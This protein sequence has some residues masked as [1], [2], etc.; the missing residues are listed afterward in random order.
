VAAGLDGFGLGQ[1]LLFGYALHVVNLAGVLLHALHE[2]L[3]VIGLELPTALTFDSLLHVFSLANPHELRGFAVSSRGP[4]QLPGRQVASS[5]AGFGESL[6]PVV[7]RIYLTGTVQVELGQRLLSESQLGGPQG[8][9]V[10]T[11][12]VTERERAVTQGELGEAL[13]SDT[14]PPSWALALSAIV[15]RLRARLAGV[16]L[17]RNRIIGNAF[18]CY[19]FTPPG[20][21]WVDVE[22]ALAAV[23][24][25]EGA[26][27]A[28]DPFAAYGPS[29][30]AVTVLRRP[31][32]TGQDGEWVEG[33]R[34]IL[35]SN[36]VR[37]LDS[38]VEALAANHELE[39]A[40][41]HAREVVRLEPYR[42]SAYRRLM[43]MLDAR[44]ERA[45]AVR[46]Y[47]DFGRLL[48]KDLGVSPSDE[49]EALYREIAR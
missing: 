31:F 48:K 23:D 24:A 47:Q 12:L 39:L 18:G 17:P 29:L 22:A 9:F 33:R 44:G 28:G 40:L 2:L 16:G 27:A 30:I 21:T 3:L 25:A 14:L 6:E 38:R 10:L 46:V 13:W 11:Y 45:E 20:E 42:E 37:A 35:A 49:T 4:H 32:L 7:L 41:T 1:D 43:R 26:I 8:R 15:S 5:P 19:Q 34:A 36:L